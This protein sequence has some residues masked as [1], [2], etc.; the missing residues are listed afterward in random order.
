MKKINYADMFTLRSD[1]RYQGYW[2]DK[3]G[4][5]TICDKDPQKLYEKIQ[6]KENP[7]AITFV[8]LANRWKDNEWDKYRDGTLDMYKAPFERAVER[9]GNTAANELQSSDI[10]AHLLEMKREDYSRRSISAQRT[11]YNK[12]Y[13]YALSVKELNEQ[14]RYN[15]AVGVKFPDGIKKPVKREAPEEE[16]VKQIKAKADTAYFGNFALFLILTGLR[17][18]EAL[19]VKWKDIDFNKKEIVCDEGVSYHGVHKVGD[20]KTDAAYRTVPLLPPAEKMLLPLKGKPND[21]VFHGDDKSAFLPRSTY[22]RRWRHYC[23][24]MGFIKD[25][26][27]TTKAKNG[28]EYVKHHY[29]NTLTAH[30]LRH[31][32]ATTLFEC[33]VDE[34]TAQRLMGHSDIAITHAVYTHLREKQNAKSVKKLMNKFKE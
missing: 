17:R 32:Y 26:P 24:E 28:R 27:T 1:G 6:K 29:K 25:E 15:P 20:L 9:F 34:F 3:N 7:Q 14:I 18:G 30:E 2:K 5:H 19:A 33:G 16:I 10:Y 13:E 31:G 22:L 8:E 23:K 11:I 4:R 12:C 21:F